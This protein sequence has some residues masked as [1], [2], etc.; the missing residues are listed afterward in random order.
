MHTW[1]RYSQ[2]AFVLPS[3]VVVGLLLGA[4]ADRWFHTTWF[5]VAGL[6]VGAI[7]GFVQLFRMYMS[8]SDK[9]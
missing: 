9:D 8:L 1:A 4:L 7:A 6:I 5:Q 2:I 3:A